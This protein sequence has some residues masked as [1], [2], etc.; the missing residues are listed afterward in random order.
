[1][2]KAIKAWF[3]LLLGLLVAACYE[4]VDLISSEEELVPC[5]HCV[6]NFT[7]TQYLSMHYLTKD[8]SLGRGI[9]DAEVTFFECYPLK[10][11]EDGATRVAREYR[12]ES[13]GNGQWRMVFPHSHG[14]E[15]EAPCR[16]QI[17]LSSGDTLR[18]ETKMVTNTQYVKYYEDGKEHQK[19]RGNIEELFLPDPEQGNYV[20]ELHG[21]QVV[22]QSDSNI[23]WHRPHFVLC[24][25]AGTVWIYKV[26]WSKEGQ[27]W[28]LEKELATDREDLT[29]GF[30]RTGR[31]FTQSKDPLAL[32]S[33]PGVAGN[34][35][36]YQYLRVPY[37]GTT[38]TISISG[39]FSGRHYG[40]SGA[41]VPMVWAEEEY[42]ITSQ[43][44]EHMK[45][46]LPYEEPE[47]I[48]TEEAGK[49]VFKRV[50]AEYDLYLKDVMQYHL[51]HD[52]GTDIIAIYDNTNIYSNIEGG[53]G[54]FGSES[55]VSFYWTCGS[56]NL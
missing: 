40:V 35:L 22:I 11:Q 25:S 26:G 43:Y 4:P 31:L 46:G 37:R 49:V 30:N 5:V 3:I 6:L 54:I 9:D 56:W 45:Q 15:E 36:H 12:F 23:Q 55:E 14:I 34:P 47:R 39:D 1:M 10:D 53:V 7:D 44:L 38:D 29:D 51:L 8:N 18:A 20:V 19:P 16:L 28:F 32:E 24:P 17:V 48:M 21:E 52:V 41:L 27:R 33:Y 13:M 42:I 2:C 50:S